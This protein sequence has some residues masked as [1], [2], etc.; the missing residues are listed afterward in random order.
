MPQAM[1]F[2]AALI[3]AGY[4]CEYHIAALRRAGVI[5]VGVYDLDSAKAAAVSTKFGLRKL[6]SLEE[7]AELGADAFHILTPPDTHAAI[8]LRALELRRHVLVEKPLA[9]DVEDCRRIQQAAQAAGRSVCVNHSLLFDPQIRKALHAAKSGKLGKIV[10]VDIFR[11][12]AYPPFGPGPLPPQY[13]SAGYPFRDLGIHALYLLEAFLGDVENVTADW[14]S[15]GGDPNL[16]YD[17]WRAQVRCRDGVGQ[18]HLSWNVRP[19]QNQMIIQGTKGI[20][21]V[22]LFAMYQVTR[23]NLPVPKAAERVLNAMSESIKPMID[24]PIGVA[25]FLTKRALPY[26]GLQDLV[27]AFYESLAKGIPAPVTPEESIRVVDW[28]ERVARAADAEYARKIAPLTLAGEIPVLVTGASGGLGGAIV[29]HLLQTGQRV[30]ILV[31]RPP[32]IIPKNVE[33]ALGDLGDPTAVD[34]AVKGASLVIHAGAT[35]K[36]PWPEHERGTIAGTQN[37]IDACLKHRVCK[38]VHISSLSVVDWAGQDG[39]TM[40]ESSP[41][42]PHAQ[43]RGSYT[44]A[45]L[46]AERRVSR[47]ARE[48]GLPCVLLRPGQIFGPNMPILT[49]AVAR[50]IGNRWIVL[51]DGTLRLPLIH[52]DDVVD[53]VSQAAAADIRSGEIIQLV[54]DRQP[55]QNEVLTHYL[56]SDARVW[57]IARSVVFALGGFSEAALGLLKR[58]SPLSR[59]RLRS[60]LSRLK[61]ESLSAGLLPNWRCRT[62]VLADPSPNA[63]AIS[64]SQPSSPAML[65]SAAR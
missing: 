17:D 53:A 32:T 64:Q 46:E 62:D 13:R 4:I 51:G 33:V 36:G 22:D 47:A 25:S 26:H 55:T 19:L 3:G 58:Q 31:R 48:L 52:V 11:S 29:R 56:G 54:H 15:L 63:P 23:K 20:L 42:E 5:N 59:Y 49:G 28:T 57:R 30:R 39:K 44:Q 43:L 14:R 24:V 1:N 6:A 35:M 60:A 61:F 34:R 10:G 40:D 21:R 41:L 65:P 9:V 2:K 8:T 18:I 16:A 12:S 50:K 45:K 37:I 27:A 7:A 38:L